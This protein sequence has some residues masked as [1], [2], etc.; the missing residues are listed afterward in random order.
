MEKQFTFV[1]AIAVVVS[2]EIT[3]C[4]IPRSPHVASA[5]A[6]LLQI[7]GDYCLSSTIPTHVASVKALLS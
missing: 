2:K 3:A 1:K 7:E 4:Q 6:L 5:K